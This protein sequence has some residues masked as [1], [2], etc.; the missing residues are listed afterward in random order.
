MSR[1]DRLA[2]ANLWVA[3]IAFGIAAAMAF[4]QALSRA[5]HSGSPSISNQ[6]KTPEQDKSKEYG[7]E[8][9]Y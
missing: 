8:R 6:T 1:T 9:G 4:M 5:A 2:L 7:Y 3:I